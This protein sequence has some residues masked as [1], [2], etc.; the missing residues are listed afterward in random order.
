MMS[1]LVTASEVGTS[2]PGQSPSETVLECDRSE[3][4]NA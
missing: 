1:G 3:V 2:P 4:S